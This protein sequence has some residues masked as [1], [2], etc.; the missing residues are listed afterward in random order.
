MDL[1]T[2]NLFTWN[3][4]GFG[5]TLGA[6]GSTE[7]FSNLEDDSEAPVNLGEAGGYLFFSLEAVSSGRPFSSTRLM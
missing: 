3:F 4:L 5:K 6:S 2:L 7:R 1:L